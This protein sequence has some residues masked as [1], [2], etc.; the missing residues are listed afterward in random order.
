MCSVTKTVDGLIFVKD[1]TGYYRQKGQWTSTLHTYIWKK[2]KGVIPKGHEIHHKDFNKDNNDISNLVCIPA[3]EHRRIHA[4]ALTDEMRDALRKNMNENARPKAIEWHR[5]SG[6]RKWHSE[7]IRHQYK[8]GVFRKQLVCSNCGKHYIG[9]VYAN[10]GN[11]YC[12]NVCKSQYRRKNK[13]DGTTHTCVICGEKF[14]TSKYRPAKT[15]SRSCANKYR[16]RLKNESKECE[17][18][19]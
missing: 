14:I 11:T 12:S 4:D 17:K 2:Y 10:G 9:T 1:S 16:W 13:L 3:N 8:Q 5:S 15:C 7:H 19:K 6:G 18:D